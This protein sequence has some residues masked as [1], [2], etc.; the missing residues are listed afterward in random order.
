MTI[1]TGG[2]SSRGVR[3]P[4]GSVA[5]VGLTTLLL[6]ILLTRIFSVTMWYHF[7]FV[8]ISLALFGLAASGVVVTILRSHFDADRA[9]SHI[10]AAAT[11]LA[12][13]IPVC[14]VLDLHLPFVPFD[15]DVAGR[16]NS[17]LPY[18]IFSA[19]FLVLSVPFF[20]SGLV[21]AL[22]FT[23][24]PD[25]THR[26]Y[27]A[28][29][30][31][32]G[33]GCALV[34][35]VLNGWS[36]PTA[37]I[38][39]AVFALLA[40]LLIHLRLRNQRAA[41]IHLTL[42][43]TTL[44]FAVVN[45]HLGLVTVHRVKSYDPQVA[46]VEERPTVYERWHPVSRVAVHPTEV[47]GNPWYWFYSPRFKAPFPSVMEVT[48]DAGARTYLFQNMPVDQRRDLFLGD[49]SD[50]VYAV[51][52][53]PKVLVVGVGGGKD[54]LSALTFDAS[55]VVAVELNPLMIDVET[56]VFRDFTGSHLL[57]PRVRVTIAEGRNYIASRSETYDV[58]KLS[59]TDTWA[60]SA[61]GAYAL[62]ENY[63]YT[64]EAIREFVAHLEPDGFLTI[65]RW[66]PKE[67]LRMVSLIR[68]A[69]RSAGV[70]DPAQRVVL[71]RGDNTVTAIVKKSPFT[72]EEIDALARR[73]DAADLTWIMG[74]GRVPTS[75]DDG[76]PGHVDVDELH[77]RA[78]LEPS[79]SLAATLP[80]SVEPPTDDRPFFFNLV[81]IGRAVKGEYSNEVGFVLQHGRALNLL[82]GLLLVTSTIA[83]A[84]VVA[85][86][87]LARTM[88]LER[89]PISARVSVSFYFL[90][91]GV[92]FM[93]VEIPMLQ[94]FVLFLGHPTYS[95]TVVLFSLL[96]S[97]G[98]GSLL[99]E[100]TNLSQR[101]GG[102]ILFPALVTMVAANAI[103]VPPLLR[104]LI[105]LPIGARVGLSV[106][107]IVPL[108]MLLG[109]PFPLGLRK[110]HDLDRG[111]VSW[112]WAVNGAASVAAPAFA[113]IV[114]ILWGF[115]AAFLL[116]GLVYIAAAAGFSGLTAATRIPR[117]RPQ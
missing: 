103:L 75:T 112:A 92:G 91:L 73:V 36:G 48:N 111:L 63:L 105:G 16:H 66:Y 62:T 46:Q 40:A 109:M 29:L 65:T 33:L 93:L 4:L 87:I 90:A 17:F 67:S 28:D 10:A 72:D 108:G 88:H 80:F 58:I 2:A 115:S 81:G 31:G 54:V 32:G 85:P 37:V 106:L 104:S 34:V 113:M 11:A 71:A 24:D 53:H 56:V 35:P 22:A 18:L 60:A 14:F 47:S 55:E 77:R 42:I 94:Q 98:L 86:L 23:H 74:P 1:A 45:E 101:G 49:V 61:V 25:R 8:A 68:A 13:S 100:R 20:F 76:E 69:L 70:E 78:V 52:R 5:L 59:V 50:L 102:K 57:D 110:A 7:A 82:V 44:G 79:A 39:T 6:E 95:L 9:A 15:L 99:C 96:I 21:V 27:F 84:L 30:A 114:A 43:M 51:T 107:T 117:Q 41:L 38:L 97:S 26:T 3:V 89:V 12:L 64:V 19:K 116:A 83:S